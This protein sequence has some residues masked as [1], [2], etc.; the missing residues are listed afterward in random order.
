[1]WLLAGIAVLSL[2]AWIA[3][4]VS[5][6]LRTDHMTREEVIGVI[7]RF[8]SNTP[9]H[10]WEWDDFVSVPLDD[11]DLDRVRQICE[12]AHTRYPP[13]GRGYTNEEGL[14]IIQKALDDL[15]A[16]MRPSD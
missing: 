12:A 13:V 8:L 5:P 10:P 2:A 3:A 6:N 11:K 4:T 14:H 9:K 15:R 16:M 7:E 1:M